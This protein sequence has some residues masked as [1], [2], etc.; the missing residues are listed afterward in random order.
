MINSKYNNVN[1]SRRVASRRVASRR[2]ASRRVASR[3]VASRRVASRRVASRRVA[4]RRVASRRVASRRVASRHVTS[5]LLSLLFTGCRVQWRINFKIRDKIVVVL[6]QRAT[7][8]HAPAHSVNM[9]Y[10][11]HQCVGVVQLTANYYLYGM[12]LYRRRGFSVT[13]P[14]LCNNLP[15]N[16]TY[17]RKHGYI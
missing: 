8:D 14:R 9:P 3:R 11:H 6:N 2:V 5:R 1:T 10:H 12:G 4:S 16:Q 15:L 7:N 13:E 17:I